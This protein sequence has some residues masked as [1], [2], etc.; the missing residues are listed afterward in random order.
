MDKNSEVLKIKLRYDKRKGKNHD[1]NWIFSF[2]IQSEREFIYTKIVRKFTS[3][4]SK[5][6][7]IEIGAGTGSNLLFFHRMGIPFT[8]IYAN[9]L[10]EDRGAVL[11]K[12]L[13]IPNIYIGDACELNYNEE[14]DIVFQS[15]VFTS[16][17]DD[18]FKK[19]LADTMWEMV[20][21]TGI[22][23][24]YD[25]KYNNPNNLDVKGIGKKEIKMLFPLAKDIEFYNVT[26]APPIG[27]RIGKLYNILNFFLPFLRTHLIAVIKK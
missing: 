26:L 24:W 10:L 9:E 27:R 3:Q 23:L 14:F 22:I 5:I 6:K 1:T 11:K 2:F 18:E 13:P 15:T 8:N 19:K 25:F 17:L 20:K 4:L 16:I 7:I 21:T 12:N